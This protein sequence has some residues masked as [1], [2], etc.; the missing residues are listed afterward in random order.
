MKKLIGFLS[1]LLLFFSFSQSVAAEDVEYEI[2]KYDAHLQLRDDNSAIFEQEI[3]YQFDS[4]FN[5]QIITLGRAG[6]MPE[7]FTILS[8]QVLVRATVNGEQR[9]PRSEISSL[10]DGYKIKVYQG[11]KEGDTVK[12]RVIWQLKNILFVYQD[13]AKL[14]WIPISDW[15]VD[16]HDVTFKVSGLNAQ[17][18]EL[19]A[20]RGYLQTE[21]I[22]RKTGNT[23]EIH[24]DH[25]PSGQKLELH[26]YWDVAALSYVLD[27]TRL[28]G[29]GK[30]EFYRV[31][32]DIIEKN[33]LYGLL[34]KTL[35]PIILIVLLILAL[36]SGW[37][38]KKVIRPKTPTESKVRLYE[39]PAD[40]AP[41]VVADKIYSVDVK[42]VSP[43]ESRSVSRFTFENMVQATIVD[44][45][46]RDCLVIE[47]RSGV[48]YLVAQKQEKLTGFEREFLQMAMGSTNA[49]PLK[50]LFSDYM[51]TNEMLGKKNKA[52]EERIRSLGQD[53][54]NRF[55]KRLNAIQ[56][57]V[58]QVSSGLENIS[59][60]RQMT[61]AE[62]RPLSFALGSFLFVFFGSAFAFFGI[63]FTMDYFD[64]R[65]IPLA[66]LALIGLVYFTYQSSIVTRDGILTEEGAQELYL[67]NSFEN[68]LRDV[69]KFDEA[70]VGAVILW[71]RILVYA[72]LFGLAKKVSK[73]LK[74]HQIR[75]E[76]ESL[77]NVVYDSYRFSAMNHAVHSFYSSGQTASSA[78]NFSVSSSGGGGGGFAGGGGGG[79]GGAF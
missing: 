78:S 20:H 32:R 6:V 50:E 17:N 51:L 77:N 36:F 43:V 24:A 46:D 72:T 35:L 28:S 59:N 4:S 18:G 13:I 29:N 65:L 5:G 42:E 1:V 67:W 63:G 31:E 60:Y 19:Y 62:R 33:K 57:E 76:N 54:K 26:G 12:V 66:I 21:P 14:K 70:E 47:D 73:Y 9:G 58:S 25:I 16:L 10:A 64:I 27:S 69:G 68:M 44:L 71:N 55:T 30:E 75:F 34:F 61:K 2:T 79:G 45:I 23:Y 40:W 41:L 39:A 8:D 38:W 74:V 22:I 37:K 52:N 53:M 11:G 7:G 49:C 56:K 3:T 48:D 15:D